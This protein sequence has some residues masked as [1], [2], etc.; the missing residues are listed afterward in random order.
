MANGE[1]DTNEFNPAELDRIE[2]LKKMILQNILTKGARER[3]G[4][5]K[6]VKPEIALQIELYLIQLYKSGKIG[7]QITEEQLKDIL[8]MLGSGKKFTIKK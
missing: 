5:V 7:S 3:L 4:R 8:E 1:M 2:Q 6:L